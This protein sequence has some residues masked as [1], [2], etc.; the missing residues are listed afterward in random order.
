MGIETAVLDGE[1]RADA[2]TS[3]E[4]TTTGNM[5]PSWAAGVVRDKK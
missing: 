1:G 2:V 4:K 5:F 3:F